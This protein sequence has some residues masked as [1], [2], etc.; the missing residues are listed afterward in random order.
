M[1]AASVE[2]LSRNSPMSF[3]YSGR[4]ISEQWQNHLFE[5]TG[6]ASTNLFKGGACKAN[7]AK[8]RRGLI[9]ST[10]Q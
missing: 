10:E 4:A 3:G 7:F 5:S 9:F 1:Q 2:N 8:A 6:E